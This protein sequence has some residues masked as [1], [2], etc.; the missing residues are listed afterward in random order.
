MTTRQ[1]DGNMPRM[2]PK[3][4]TMT[5]ATTKCDDAENARPAREQAEHEAQTD[6]EL[7]VNRDGREDFGARELVLREECHEFLHARAH[8]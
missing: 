8:R 7:Q 4:S 1:P 3:R 2:P 6:G 5:M